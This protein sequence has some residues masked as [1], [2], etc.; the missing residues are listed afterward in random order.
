MKCVEKIGLVKFDFLGLKTATVIHDTLKIIRQQGKTPPDLHNI[1]L[2]DPKTYEVFSTGNT[3]GIFQVES[4]GMRQYLRMLKPH[5]FEDIIAMLALY[6]PGPLSSDMVNHFI[7]CKH[8]TIKVSYPHPCL[9][10]ILEPT[11]GVIVY[12]E[13]VMAV[14]TEIANYS[15]G[16]S[17]L[18]RRAMGKKNAKDMEA[19]E[20]RFLQG[21]KENNIPNKTALEIFKLMKKFAEYGFNKSH[22]AAYALI[23]YYTAYLKAHHTIEFMAALISTE[24]NNT[25]KLYMYINAC[26]RMGI[27][28][29]PPNINTSVST[30]SIADKTILFGLTGIKNVGE[31]AVHA[32]VAEREA[33]GPYQGLL[34]FCSRVDLHKVSKRVIEFFIKGGAMDCFDCPRAALMAALEKAVA[35]GQNKAKERE[36]GMLSMLDLLAA[37]SD[38]DSE[39]PVCFSLDEL[40]TPE[41]EDIEK[42]KMEKEALGFFLTTHPLSAFIR[43]MQR[44]RLDTLE[45]CREYSAE[46]EVKIGCIVTDIT[47]K[48]SRNGEKYARLAIEDLSGVGEITIWSRSY[49]DEIKA[50]L[51]SEIPLYIEGKTES[52]KSDLDEGTGQARLIASSI[53]S[54]TE[55]INNN[56]EPIELSIKHQLCSQEHLEALS[57][58]LLQYPGNIPVCL[59][60]Y[61]NEYM[62]QLNLGSRFKVSPKTALW[63]EL[64]TWQ[65]KNN[66]RID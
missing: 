4:S 43:D 51:T 40:N 60:V 16:E 23:S 53:K 7:K 8:G 54:L 17:D 30:F 38:A 2:A 32:V 58:I 39:E 37:S 46:I 27:T 36:Q 49:N 13:Q 19:Q 10:T 64:D 50:L 34:D 66:D 12:Q 35:Y 44:L 3:D 28:I 52:S 26:Q 62:V 14:A 56:T 24:L 1:S 63:E 11:Y 61:F 22:S 21:A 48:Y 65:G 33:N 6:R 9:K 5:C 25:A 47:E 59:W 42:Q 15:L 20:K 18:L 57:A 55:T 29:N 45:S 41:W 31:D